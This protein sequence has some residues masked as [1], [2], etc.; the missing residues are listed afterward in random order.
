MI[1]NYNTHEVNNNTSLD[2]IKKSWRI[3]LLKYHQDR[4]KKSII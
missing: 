2:K 4:N 3:L 1:D